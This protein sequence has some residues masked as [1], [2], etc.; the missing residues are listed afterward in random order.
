MDEKYLET[1]DVEIYER[2]QEI[3]EQRDEEELILQNLSEED[4]VK[5]LLEKYKQNS[6]ILKK[7]KFNVID[8]GKQ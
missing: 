4:R 6:E 5:F 1:E 8:G 7:G 2:L 3:Q